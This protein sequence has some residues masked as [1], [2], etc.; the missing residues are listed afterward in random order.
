LAHAELLD[1]AGDEEAILPV[2]FPV[3]RDLIREV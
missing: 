3:T 2:R 1:S